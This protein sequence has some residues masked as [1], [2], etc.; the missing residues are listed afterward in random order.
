MGVL[1]EK[2]CKVCISE[3]ILSKIEQPISE[4]IPVII[5]NKYNNIYKKI[6]INEL[7]KINIFFI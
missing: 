6:I 4:N 1:N 5:F 7:N 2:R 3:T